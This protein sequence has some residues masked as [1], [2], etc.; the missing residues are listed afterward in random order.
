MSKR[1]PPSA[2]TVQRIRRH[3]ENYWRKSGTSP[4]PDPAITEV[5]ITGLASNM[6][7]AQAAR[8]ARATPIPTRKSRSASLADA[9]SAPATR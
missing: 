9:G 8:S 6:E 7:E 1:S 2:S 3:V 5:V 4:H